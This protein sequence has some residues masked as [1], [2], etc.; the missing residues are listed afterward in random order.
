MIINFEVQP[1]DRISVWSIS[2]INAGHVRKMQRAEGR[3]SGASANAPR[4]QG[5]VS[6]KVSA[7]ELDHTGSTGAFCCSEC[8]YALAKARTTACCR[9]LKNRRTGS[10]EAD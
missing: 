5:E 4:R 7:A 6:T 3:S 2:D 9:V 10:L 1:S 8:H